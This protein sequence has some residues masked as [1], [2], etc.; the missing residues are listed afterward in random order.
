MCKSVNNFVKICQV[1]VSSDISI[2]S[3][4]SSSS[5]V[6]FL[7]ALYLKSRKSFL[8]I[9]FLLWNCHLITWHLYLTL[10]AWFIDLTHSVSVLL[11]RSVSQYLHTVG[12]RYLL[13][14]YIIRNTCQSNICL[15]SLVL[16]FTVYLLNQFFMLRSI[17]Q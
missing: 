12:Q 4:S 16:I 6:S 8:F 10:F 3:G 1:F 14:I 7:E 17:S 15:Q 13:C 2:F 5:R 9:Q 11:L